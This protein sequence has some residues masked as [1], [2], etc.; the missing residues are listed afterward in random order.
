[1]GERG[2]GKCDLKESHERPKTEYVRTYISAFDHTR[3][4][5]WVCVEPCVRTYTSKFERMRAVQCVKKGALWSNSSR[6]GRTQRRAHVQTYRHTFER[7]EQHKKNFYK[8][9][10]KGF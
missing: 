4:G 5:A 3:A 1:M 9:L 7:R 8:N 2:G 10:H 6:Q